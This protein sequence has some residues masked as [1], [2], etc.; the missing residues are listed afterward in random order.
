[1]AAPVLAIAMIAHCRLPAP[2]LSDK[3]VGV[4][5][6]DARQATTKLEF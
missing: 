5:G 6:A 3:P 4:G 2:W 1:M